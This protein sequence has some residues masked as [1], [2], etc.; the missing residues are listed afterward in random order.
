MNNEKPDNKL[1]QLIHTAIGRDSAPFD[2]QRWKQ[3]HQ[4]E[5]TQFRSQ[6]GHPESQA[7]ASTE[8]RIIMIRTLKFAAA[9]V[10]FIGVCLGLPYIGHRD[11]GNAAFAQILEQMEQAKVV[12]W[13]LTF[14]NHVTSR[15]GRRTW[16]ETETREL[17]YR[18]PGVY[19]EVLHPTIHGQVEHTTITDAVNL[20]SLSLVPAENR[21]YLRELA[22][23]TEDP[24][25]PFRWAREHMSKSDLEWV[26]KRVTA[27]GE[28]NVFR[29]A[30]KQAD[31][32][33]WSYDFWIDA[34]TKR[35]VAVQVPGADIYDP[36]T[37][38]ARENPIEKDW[39][40]MT[41]A[42]YVQ[43]EIDFD[44]KLDDS[45]FR[46]ESPAGYTLQTDQRAQVTEKEMVDYLGIMAEYNDSAF[47]DQPY[48]ID[49]ARLNEIYDKAKEDRT[50]AEQKL[51][52][53]VDHYKMASLNMM[54]TG[55]FVED[56][57]VTGSFR[58]LGKGV[59]LGDKDRIVCW[60]RLKGAATYRVVYGDLNIKDMSADDLPLPAE[61]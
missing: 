44:A 61:P 7:M 12:T 38:P 13:R 25:G 35:L 41:P 11:S 60:Y 5:I 19:R 27:T 23:T 55:H 53:T 16:V 48:S 17:A 58:Y 1:D 37:D 28:V 51:L 39:S 20:K 14:Y 22:V 46:L 8:R 59:R 29:R 3:E 54:P 56:R 31:N 24:R 33:D 36:E 47:P 6:A 2:F 26:G 45:L 15:D 50:A 10:I 30:F 52:D 43:S 57:T 9:A 49:S 21:A 34:K 18:A 4:R 40:T 32:R 42:C